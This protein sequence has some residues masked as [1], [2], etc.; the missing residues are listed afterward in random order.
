[1]L[2]YCWATIDYVM[3]HHTRQ[4]LAL[5]DRAEPVRPFDTTL[6][7]PCTATLARHSQQANVEYGLYG[8]GDAAQ[9]I[10]GVNVANSKSMG[11]FAIM[12][13]AAAID[14]KSWRF[15]TVVVDS[16]SGE[17]LTASRMTTKLYY[18]RR[19]STFFGL[20]QLKPTP[21][22]TDN[23]GV[24]TIARDAVGTTSLIYIIRHCRFVQQA[25]EQGEILVGQLD[26]R[27]N[28]TDGLT[29][30]LPKTTT[31][32]DNMF[33]MGFPQEAY[34]YWLA[35]KVF[36]QFKPRNIAPPPTPPIDKESILADAPANVRVTTPSS[37]SSVGT[38]G[39][40]SCSEA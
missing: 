16:T 40:P 2:R 36:K 23:D 18:Y 3:R 34:R 27:I 7:S 14:W 28:P 21:L 22:L 15:H 11:G 35:S 32:R 24:W 26:G 25:Q 12:L 5:Q 1:M 30:Y 33:L 37:T 31:I 20:P 8:C 4:G 10:P 38:A 6:P 29:K 9:A 39:G 13:G 19:L 17:M